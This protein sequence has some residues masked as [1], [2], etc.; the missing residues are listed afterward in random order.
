MDCQNSKILYFILNDFKIF[1]RK[2]AD[3]R[4]EES[5]LQCYQ[6]LDSRF[7]PAQQLVVT[8]EYVF[9]PDIVFLDVLYLGV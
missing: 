6:N 7:A 8:N 5:C 9:I 2:K 1:S 4:V 3:Y